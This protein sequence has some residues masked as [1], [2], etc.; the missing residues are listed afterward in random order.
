MTASSA[1]LTSA[2]ATTL[3]GPGAATKLVYTT[4]PPASTSTGSTF[5][6]VVAEQDVFGN[7]ETA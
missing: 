3:V 4:A 5:G 7:V 6:V 1:G 2:T